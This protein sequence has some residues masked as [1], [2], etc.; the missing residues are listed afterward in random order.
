VQSFGQRLEIK[1]FK[2]IPV[3]KELV[4]LPKGQ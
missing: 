3:V 4:A 1:N 2:K